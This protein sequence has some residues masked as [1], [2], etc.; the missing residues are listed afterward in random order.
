MPITGTS[1]EQ[2]IPIHVSINKGLVLQ[3]QL[4]IWA[5]PDCLLIRNYQGF[6]ALDLC[7][8]K[9]EEMKQTNASNEIVQDYLLIKKII[10]KGLKTLT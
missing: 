6:T 4:F 10:E 9:I 2:E 7:E 8:T 3:T 5:K 1:Y